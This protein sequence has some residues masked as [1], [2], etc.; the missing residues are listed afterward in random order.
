MIFKVMGTIMVIAGCGGFGFLIAAAYR[1]EVRSL[2]ELINALELMECELQYRLTP[3]PQLCRHAAMNSSGCIKRI[4]LSLAQEMDNQIS[5]D[6]AKCVDSALTRTSGIPPKTH[7]CIQLLGK[8][9][10]CFDLDGQLTGIASVKED[11]SRILTQY[12]QNQDTR[13]R[14]YQTLG[15][16]AGAALAIL[17][18]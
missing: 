2:R 11:C 4:L 5:P 10:G 13:I 7:S 16:C 9:L 6:V 8:S 12:I 14:S 15:I 3:L 1:R 18:I 17:F